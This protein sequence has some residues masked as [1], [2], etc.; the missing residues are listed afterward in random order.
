MSDALQQQLVPAERELPNKLTILPVQGKP[1]F[2][3][4]FTPM[5]VQSKPELRVVEAALGLGAGFLGLALTLEPDSE[6]LAADDLFR[7]GV[8]ARI[9]RRINLPDGGLNIFISVLKRFRLVNVDHVQPGLFGKERVIL[10]DLF[11]LRQERPGQRTHLV[12]VGR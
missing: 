6:G 11:H 9:V 10:G 3:G 4:V 2:P 5:V 8:A 7:V 1:L 12:G